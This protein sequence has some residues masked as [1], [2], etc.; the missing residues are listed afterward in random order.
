MPVN[1]IINA[2]TM[3]T[4]LEWSVWEAKIEYSTI[5]SDIIPKLLDYSAYL[6]FLGS[7]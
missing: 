5:L 6:V 7:A 4:T 2:Q 1:C 3:E